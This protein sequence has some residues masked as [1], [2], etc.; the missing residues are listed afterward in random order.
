MAEDKILTKIKALEADAY[1]RTIV[2]MDQSDPNKPDHEPNALEVAGGMLR[3]F[4]DEALNEWKKQDPAL[5]QKYPKVGNILES[6][7]D[8]KNFEP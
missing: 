1:Y 2:R 3:L 7:L 8:P 6:A 4:G 5:H